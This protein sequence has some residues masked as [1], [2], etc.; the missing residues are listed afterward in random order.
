MPLKIFEITHEDGEKEWVSGDTIIKALV[1][2]LDTNDM[3]ISEILDSEIV[4]LPKEKWSEY[5]VTNPDYDKD[6]PEDKESQTFEEYMKEN[7]HPELI[8]GTMYE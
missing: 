8:C 1:V 4:E 5:S 6:D 2:Y 7:A 3:V